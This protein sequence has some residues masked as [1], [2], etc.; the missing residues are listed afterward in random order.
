MKEMNVAPFNNQSS[1]LKGMPK[2]PL[3]KSF[4]SKILTHQLLSEVLSFIDYDLQMKTVFNLM[5]SNR[6]VNKYINESDELW[7]RCFN[8]IDCECK[9]CKLDGLSLKS[10]LQ[11]H[12]I[13]G[14]HVNISR[15]AF[16]KQSCAISLSHRRLKRQWKSRFASRIMISEALTPEMTTPL[17]ARKHRLIL[18]RKYRY[19]NESTESEL[20][21]LISAFIKTECELLGVNSFYLFLS[22][23]MQINDPCTSLSVVRPSIWNWFRCNS[24]Q[25]VQTQQSHVLS[26]INDLIRAVDAIVPDYLYWYH[27]RLYPHTVN[28]R[29]LIVVVHKSKCYA[30]IAR[31]AGLSLNKRLYKEIIDFL[32]SN[33]RS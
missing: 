12:S 16:W 22:P 23:L 25:S 13:F 10:R 5:L 21:D 26:Y 27:C 32:T 24:S 15:I 17:L 3:E 31:V 7:C 14:N 1:S 6:E 29:G 30:N 9:C 18:N 11:K 28:E 19:E 4:N 33:N 8:A 20:N 2:K